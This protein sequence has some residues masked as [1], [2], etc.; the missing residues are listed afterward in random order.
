MA[1]VLVLPC[2]GRGQALARALVSDGHAVR[3]TTRRPERTEAIRAAGA[4]AVVA[5]PDRVGTVMEAIAG[6]TVVCILLGSAEG[7]PEQVAAL[8]DSRLQ[9]LWER[10]V[11]TPVRGVVYEAAGT[12]PAG[13]L[14]HGR[15]VAERAQATWHIPLAVLEADPADPERWLAEA[16]AAVGRLLA[17]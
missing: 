17:P 8:H 1:R 9:M 7:P 12:V 14:A 4:E 2:G 5:D 16:R 15:A 6:V 13:A 11:D 3:G 10:L